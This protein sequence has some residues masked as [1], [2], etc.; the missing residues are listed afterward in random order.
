LP[1]LEPELDP[2]EPV[3]PVPELEPVAPVSDDPLEEELDPPESA[4]VIVAFMFGWGVQWYLKVP[5]WLKVC[6]PLAPFFSTPV[7]HWPLVS[8]VAECPVGPLL[9][10][11]TVSPTFTVIDLGVNS[12]SLIV[13]AF[14]AAAL[15][16][17][18]DDFFF[19]EPFDSLLSEDCVLPL[20]ARGVL[21]ADGPAAPGG[22]PGSAGPGGSAFVDVGDDFDELPSS[23]SSAGGAASATISA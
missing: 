3:D 7:S 15:A 21:E 10:H 6:D 8:E 16:V 19:L 23:A 13:T 12:K 14:D 20:S 11:S 1:E 17:L 9:V 5:A 22:S 2:V 18:S 4:T